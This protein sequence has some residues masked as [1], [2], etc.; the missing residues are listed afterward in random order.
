MAISSLDAVVTVLSDRNA[1]VAHVDLY[2]PLVAS[3]SESLGTA[4][5]AS[6]R[7]NGDRYSEAIALDLAVGRALES[8]GRQLRHR[9]EKAVR[10][11]FRGTDG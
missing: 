1:T 11:A 8:L 9:G 5:G 7:E 10:D 6:K 4:T 3:A 2:S